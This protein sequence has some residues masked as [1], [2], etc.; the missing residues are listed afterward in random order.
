MG[1]PQNNLLRMP[2]WARR[3]GYKWHPAAGRGTT[4]RMIDVL[5]PWATPDRPHRGDIRT[6][7]R[8]VRAASPER[9]PGCGAGG[10]RLRPGREARRSLRPRARIVGH[11]GRADRPRGAGHERFRRT[12]RGYPTPGAARPRSRLQRGPPSTPGRRVRALLQ[13]GASAPS[14][15]AAAADSASCRARR[16]HH[17]NPRSRGAPSRLSPSRVKRAGRTDP[18]VRRADE[19]CSHH[20][21]GGAGW[22]ADSELVRAFCRELPRP[23]LA[24]APKGSR[25]GP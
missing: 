16:P 11:A 4:R 14:A 17:G 6:E 5:R 18:T 25:E 7:R 10:S 24:G 22:L 1:V 12:V 20:G 21:G 9:H 8:V 23:H 3:P 13:R 15:R 2:P 19:D